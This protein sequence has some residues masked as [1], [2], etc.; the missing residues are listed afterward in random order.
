MN[1]IYKINFYVENKDFYFQEV[2][3]KL[4]DM[5]LSFCANYAGK[6]RNGWSFE[7]MDITEIQKRNLI[8]FI[9]KLFNNNEFRFAAS[10]HVGY[11]D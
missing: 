5:N 4:H 1:P 2:S 3:N 7:V 6:A 11:I 9:R 10:F 8:H